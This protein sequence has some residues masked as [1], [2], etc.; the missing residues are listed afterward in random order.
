MAK[1]YQPER[2]GR[3][4]TQTGNSNVRIRDLLVRGG[5]ELGSALSECT[6]FDSRAIAHRR[7]ETELL[8][9]RCLAQSTLGI[10][11]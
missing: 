3:W 5:A 7:D 8:R 2:V 11:K 1:T 6:R 10:T 9:K 4:D